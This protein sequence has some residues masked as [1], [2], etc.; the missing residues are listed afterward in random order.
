MS[1]LDLLGYADT[2][3]GTRERYSSQDNPKREKP[4]A[5]DMTERPCSRV[6]QRTFDTSLPTPTKTRNQ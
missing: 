4:M 6:V 3:A 1:S 5:D 2:T